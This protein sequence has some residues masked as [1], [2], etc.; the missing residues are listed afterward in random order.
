MERQI[1]FR[2]KRECDNLWEYGYV[3][4]FNSQ[5]GLRYFLNNNIAITETV[6]QFTGLFDKNGNK[7]FEGD[8]YGMGEENITYIVVFRNSRFIGKQIGSSSYAG[9]EYWEKDIEVIGNIHDN[10]ELLK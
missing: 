3:S 2:G 10:P 7:I 8:I 5:R 6:G 4:W 9:L 1:L